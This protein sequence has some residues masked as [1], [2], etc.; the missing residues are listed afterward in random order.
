MYSKLWKF[1]TNSYLGSITHFSLHENANERGT[2][3]PLE[4]IGDTLY[5]SDFRSKVI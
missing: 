1:S 3:N 5:L 2:F 4:E